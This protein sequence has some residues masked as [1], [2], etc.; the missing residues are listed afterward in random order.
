MLK[1]LEELCLLPGVS[2]FEEPVREYIK[3]K[4][5][6]ECGADRVWTDVLGTLYVEKKA[7]PK[8]RKAALKAS[9]DPNWTQPKLM[10]AAHMDEVG[11]III[12]IEENGYLRFLTMGGIDKRVVLGRKVYVGPKMV[13]GVIGLKAIH[14]TTPAER[15]VAPD[16]TSMYIDI[17]AKSGDEARKLVDLGD[18][19]VFHSDFLEFGEGRIKAKAIDDRFGCAVYNFHNSGDVTAVNYA[20]G[21]SGYIYYN[22][23][24]YIIYNDNV[25]DGAITATNGLAGGILG[26]ARAGS[27]DFTY[28]RCVNNG[29]IKGAVAGGLCG[30]S[31]RGTFNDCYN[32]G[33]V[34]SDSIGRALIAETDVATLNRCWNIGQITLTAGELTDS[35]TLVRTT[36]NVTYNVGNYDLANV[37]YTPKYGRPEGYEDEWLTNGHFCYLLNENKGDTLYYQTL[38]E[39]PHP[40]FDKTHKVVSI[41]GNGQYVNAGGDGIAQPM[42]NSQKPKAIYDLSGR[43]VAKPTRGLYIIG[44]RKVFVK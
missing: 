9:G 23:L 21:I 26:Y 15:E 18:E 25:N 32:T 36:N 16:F 24:V 29:A 19:V 35:L 40:V 4:A 30:L 37:A 12:H 7:S 1:Y 2:S 3:E 6:E 22:A 43:R 17:G 11:F 33:S 34:E 20:G 31:R 13:P 41:D 5:L 39:D 14:L 42:A 38:G 27:H 8:A 28:T 44:G 10:M